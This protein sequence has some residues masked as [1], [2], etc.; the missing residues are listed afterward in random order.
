MMEVLQ[1][2]RPQTPRERH[3]SAF[4]C[5]VGELM[6]S[7][8]DDQ[9]RGAEA[10]ILQVVNRYIDASTRAHLPTPTTTTPAQVYHGPPTTAPY[11]HLQQPHPQQQQAQYTPQ[12]GP[13]SSPVPG[14]STEPQWTYN[15]STPSS[16][17]RPP[18]FS[19]LTPTTSRALDLLINPGMTRPLPE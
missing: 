13:G 14:P 12:Y 16:A 10:A 11:Q 8:A 17:S 18:T 5:Y 3:V 4:M 15:A 1:Q 6:L 2:V 7:V 19:D 9:L